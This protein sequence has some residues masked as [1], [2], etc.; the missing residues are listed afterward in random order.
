MNV[1]PYTDAGAFRDRVLPFLLQRE[2]EH[3]LMISIILRLA[4]GSGRW[5]DEPPVL[6]ALE[7]GGQVVASAVQTP[8]YH[9][10][11]VRMEGETEAALV[12]YLHACSPGLSGV[13]GPET[14]VSAFATCWATETG[15]HAECEKGMGVYQLDR[16]I[17]PAHP[18]GYSEQATTADTTLLVR[19]IDDFNYLTGADRR[20]AEEI[21]A[22][23]LEKQHYWLWKNPHPVSLAASSGPTPH[24]M[25]IGP[26]YTPPEQRG[27]GYASANVAALSQRLLYSGR[28]FCYLFTD[29]A[30]PTAN[31]IYRKIGYRQ[32]CDFASVR[33]H[34]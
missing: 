28:L 29:L 8:P 23:A 10:H 1:I 21:V 19:W 14:A 17:S 26:V 13:L 31:S 16:V 3:N 33:F 5:G 9:L 18:G 4:D 32:V 34:E 15:M 2:A 6:L 7:D 20:S 12:E 27:K 25:R 24:G 22:Q 11:L 30:N